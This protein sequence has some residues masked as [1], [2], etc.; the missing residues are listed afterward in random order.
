MSALR[1]L[2]IGAFIFGAIWLL[3][4]Y[5]G[6][7]LPFIIVVALALLFTFIARNTVFGRQ[8]YAIGGNPEAARLSG[9]PIRR[10]I[11]PVF[12]LCNTLAA[13]AGLV[14][15]A[16]VNAATMSAGTMYELDA[17]AACLMGGT[18]TVTGAIIGALIMVS[19]DNG[20]SIMN[21]GRSGSIS[22]RARS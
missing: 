18:G 16:R 11:L 10:R 8:I 13:I 7:P 5:K 20:M 17:I 3:N 21:M 12:V 2:L 19:L 14:L 22:S 1:I 15:T 4:S 9:I 6:I